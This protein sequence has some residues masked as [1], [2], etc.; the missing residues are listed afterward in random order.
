MHM[1]FE[2]SAACCGEAYLQTA[3]APGLPRNMS[4]GDWI[5]QL[6]RL[7]LRGRSERRE[8]VR[9]EP[10]PSAPEEREES[11]RSEEADYTADENPQGSA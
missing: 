4:L 8:R 3:F 10:A 7:T 6:S 1:K 5:P 2:C 11:V 9:L